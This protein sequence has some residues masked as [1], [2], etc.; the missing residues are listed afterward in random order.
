MRGPRTSPVMMERG[1]RMDS[2]CVRGGLVG[3][4]EGLD[5]RVK[6]LVA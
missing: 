4:A 6:R 1:N 2:V 5:V 3:F